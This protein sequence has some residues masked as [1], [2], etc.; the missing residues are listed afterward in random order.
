MRRLRPLL[1]AAIVT[2][3]F[4]G[5]VP[6]VFA[7]NTCRPYGE[8]GQTG[9]LGN[10]Y[11]AGLQC[12]SDNL[13]YTLGTRSTQ[14]AGGLFEPVIGL[15]Y[16]ISPGRDWTFSVKADIREHIGDYEVNSLPEFSLA[17]N[18]PHRDGAV[19]FTLAAVWGSYTPTT[20]PEPIQRT[21]FLAI[22]AF[23]TWKL[24]PSVN[25]GITVTGGYA[26]YSTSDTQSWIETDLATWGRLGSSIDWNLTFGI[27]TASGVSPLKFDT[28]S[29]DVQ[30][31]PGLT[32]HLDSQ[33]AVSVRGTWSFQSATMSSLSYEVRTTLLG[34]AVTFAYDPVG[35]TVTGTYD[36]PK[37]GNIGIRYD[38]V[39]SAVS[40]VFQPH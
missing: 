7:A 28:W 38:Q 26:T 18:S 40:A 25:A 33:W 13:S 30:A 35:Q 31:S 9:V 17:W 24:A 3:A 6:P 2:T 16:A 20:I 37:F 32:F 23:P 1:L 11:G 39:H 22:A 10:F 8:F 4:T 19:Q 29:G 34:S 12:S 36:F 5:V 27:K 14:F 15:N 21:E